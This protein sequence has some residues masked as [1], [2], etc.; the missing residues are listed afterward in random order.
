MPSDD[1]LRF[2]GGPLPYSGWWLLLGILLVATVIAWCA[3]VFVWTLSPGRLRALPVINRI[4]AGL[5]RRRFIR[6][7]RGAFDQ[8]RAGVI[9]GPQAGAAISRSVRSF[10]FVSTGVRAQY[11]HISDMADGPLA[12]AAPLL[13]RLNDVQFSTNPSNDIAALGRSAE[14]LISTWT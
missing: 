13:T 6:A 10:L 9:S 14:E 8:Y 3:G 12:A 1:L 4:H 7:V 2:I 11:L 5:T